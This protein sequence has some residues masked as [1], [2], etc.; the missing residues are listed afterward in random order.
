MAG[1]IVAVIRES[2]QCNQMPMQSSRKRPV[3]P[4]ADRVV[5]RASTVSGMDAVSMTDESIAVVGLKRYNLNSG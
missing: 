3:M 2:A 1:A 5:A 4:D